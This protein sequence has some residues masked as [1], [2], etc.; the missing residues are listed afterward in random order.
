MASLRLGCG[1]IML[2]N[3][4]RYAA[5]HK[6]VLQAI[7][8]SYLPDCTGSRG[9]PQ[10]QP[11]RPRWQARAPTPGADGL[12]RC[13]TAPRRRR[14][15]WCGCIPRAISKTPQWFQKAAPGKR[16][17]ERHPGT[18]NRASDHLLLGHPSCG[19]LG[20]RTPPENVIPL[21]S[22][23]EERGKGEKSPP[24]GCRLGKSGTNQA[25]SG[26]GP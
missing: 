17:G 11:V 23:S 4:P 14:G 13:A 25:D 10:R 16:V 26:G 21:S 1:I 22:A 19:A 18:T 8:C 3:I 12:A 9:C 15:R 5:A 24:A 7:L 20:K 6:C 2:A